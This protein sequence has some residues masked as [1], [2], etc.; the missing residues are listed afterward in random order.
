MANE[1]NGVGAISPAGS[2]Q[3]NPYYDFDDLDM[4]MGMY[5]SMGGMNGSI[6]DG[7]YGMGMMPYVPGFG[8]NN[9]SYFNNM[10][11]YQKFYN[12][13]NI[14]QQRMQRN[15]DLRINASVEGIKSAASILKD[16]IVNN[17]QDQIP[18]AFEKYLNSVRA[19]YGEGTDSEI[20]SRAM[21]LYAQMNGNKSLIQDL[22]DYGHGSGTQGFIQALT[23]GMYN[24]HS[25]EDN[26]SNITGAPVGSGE[27]TKH[28][29]GRLAG[30]ATVG[31]TTGGIAKMLTKGSSNASAA[32]GIMKIFKSGKAGVIGLIAGGLAAVMSFL[33]GKVTT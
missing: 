24:R 22:R 20:K 25:A 32:K 7:S 2:F 10:R 19:A 30:A 21:T 18:E 16:K 23:F 9:Q 12:D 6:F 3:Y 27:K 4:N 5:P 14:E 8:G 33:T 31:V 1:I 29:F 17:E 11:D 26:I 13:Y 28:N 15:A